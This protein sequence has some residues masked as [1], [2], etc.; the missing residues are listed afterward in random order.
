MML[1]RASVVSVQCANCGQDWAVAIDEMSPP[2][3]KAVQIAML[4]RN[5]THY[6]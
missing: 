4:K 3:R 6:A 2:V 1:S 5:P